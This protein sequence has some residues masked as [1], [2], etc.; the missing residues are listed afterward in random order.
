MRALI[1]VVAI[2]SA[3]TAAAQSA[4]LKQIEIDNPRATPTVAGAP[5][6]AAY[7]TI[8]N[9]GRNADRLI[10]A[11]TPRAER[12]ELHVMSMSGKVMR[13]RQVAAIEVKPGETLR[14][15]PGSPSGQHLM[16]VGLSQPLKGGERFPLA[17]RF[18]KAGTIEVTLIVDEAKRTED[19]H[20]H[21]H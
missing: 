16:L 9:R 10:G 17:L 19:E 12:V 18:E 15:Q 8:T 2:G 4:A 13:M 21:G 5:T 1:G 3:A 7:L 20:G 11:S 6:G 14:M